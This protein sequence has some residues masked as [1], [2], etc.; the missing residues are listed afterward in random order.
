MLR[1]GIILIVIFAFLFVTDASSEILPSVIFDY[2]SVDFDQEYVEIQTVDQCIC[3]ESTAYNITSP[4]INS[5]AFTS[6][7][8]SPKLLQH[9]IYS[10]SIIIPESSVDKPFCL[11]P[12]DHIGANSAIY[13]NGVLCAGASVYMSSSDDSL[14]A[15]TTEIL[16][17]SFTPDTSVL[18]VQIYLSNPSYS[19]QASL[20]SLYF[21]Y[22]N[23]IIRKYEK[24]LLV[25][26]L[27]VFSL[28]VLGLYH[29][30]VFCIT[31]FDRR[32][33]Y[34]AS[35]CLLFALHYSVQGAMPFFII[36]PSCIT[37][38]YSHISFVVLCAFPIFSMLLFY[39]FYTKIIH[40]YTLYAGLVISMVFTA[41]AI[42]GTV[43][44]RHAITIP[45]LIFILGVIVFCCYILLRSYVLKVY[46]DILPIV[47]L[48][49]CLLFLASGIICMLLVSDA[50]N[51][52][53]Y[54][55]ILFVMFLPTLLWRETRLDF[56]KEQESSRQLEV[57][58]TQLEAEVDKRTEELS[59]S[60]DRVRRFNHFQEGMT[61]LIAHD[62]KS[63]LMQVLNIDNITVQDFP[64][65]RH[66]GSTMLRMVENMMA[67]YNYNTDNMIVSYTS[68]SVCQIIEDVLNDFVY[69]LSQR[70]LKVQITSQ[71]TYGLHT[72]IEIFK[73]VLCN[74]LSN[75][76]RFSPNATTINIK[77]ESTGDDGLKVW[78]SNQGPPLEES[79][80]INL[81]QQASTSTTGV[82]ANSNTS[83]LGLFLCKMGVDALNGDIGVES[84]GV[85]GADFWFVLP[86][87]TVIDKTSICK[88]FVESV[89]FNLSLDDKEY[90]KPYA[91][92][93]KNVKVYDSSL[94]EEI[95]SKIVHP[96]EMT[97]K[98]IDNLRKAAYSLDEDKLQEMLRCVI[99]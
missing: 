9:T 24:V 90:L 22:E 66:S 76:F 82:D 25:D 48:F 1:N 83:G 34:Y 47:T 7:T 53:N 78:V 63:P 27:A 67:L 98:W 70:A 28:F 71:E 77:L 14:A 59:H 60:L 80:K 99:A 44:M 21:G 57:L 30:L 15:S 18:N 84:D 40:R 29:L 12:A 16:V 46:R 50:F 54:S 26:F 56:E 39:T 35:H 87:V 74:L 93:I 3:D 94:I 36:F 62:I 17:Y 79:I 52:I 88:L 91:A 8:I 23:Q 20:S 49:I 33:L 86:G 72:D 11:Y 81:F 68:F 64:Y 38:I 58:T 31:G 75:A 92:Q 4:G 42:F 41:I 61:H 37:S 43:P 19:T 95:L 89:D 2:S 97:Q 6:G 10:Y 13:I 96:N 85:Q 65:L 51:F 32:F 69:Q 55:I 45:N 5:E 73:R